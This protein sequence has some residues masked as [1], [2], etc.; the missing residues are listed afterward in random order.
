MATDEEAGCR[1]GR[2]R[3]PQTHPNTGAFALRT[4]PERQRQRDVLGAQLSSAVLPQATGHGSRRQ[5]PP[6]PPFCKEQSRERERNGC[7]Q[8][9]RAGIGTRVWVQRRSSHHS[10]AGGLGP[11]ELR[12]CHE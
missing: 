5:A 12:I 3:A 6:S 8:P 2:R 11:P 9:G 4:K 1:T 10:A 7:P